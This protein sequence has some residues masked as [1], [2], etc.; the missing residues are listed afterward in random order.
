[1]AENQGCSR[2]TPGGH[3]GKTLFWTAAKHMSRPTKIFTKVY[4]WNRLRKNLKPGLSTILMHTAFNN[5]ELE[6]MMKDIPA[7]G[8]EWRQK[9]FDFF[10]SDTCKELLKEEKIQLVNWRQLKEA[11]YSN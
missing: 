10:M 2:I 8:S 4:T 1:M 11:F 5:D 7:W 9:D 6:A 3:L